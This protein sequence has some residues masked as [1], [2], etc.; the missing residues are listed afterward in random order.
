MT[1][2]RIVAFVAALVAAFDACPYTRPE[3]LAAHVGFMQRMGNALPAALAFRDESGRSVRLGDYYGDVPIVLVFAWFGC[4]TLCSTVI[5]NLAQSV[6]KTD[7]APDRYRVIVASIDPRD[8]PADAVRMKRRAVVEED[9]TAWHFL[10]GREDAIDALA[11]AVGFRY[12]Y[13]AD[14]HQYA[15]P[16]GFVI[17]TPDGRVSRYFFGFD[18]AP[19]QLRDALRDAGN[20]AI[21]SPVDR[22]LLLCFHFAPTG[23]YS[24]DVLQALRI[25]SVLLLGCTLVFVVV[26]RRTASSG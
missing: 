9:A 26:K 20:D 6:A 8:A 13:D 18:F 1:L 19:S 25:G 17:L 16:A 10:T 5:G 24:A 3:T 11:D 12:V 4:R 7:V 21:A 22:L 2:L 15:H 14:T 23:R